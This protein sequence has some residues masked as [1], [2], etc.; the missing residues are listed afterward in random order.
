MEDENVLLWYQD[1]MRV[2][3]DS[4]RVP[5]PMPVPRCHSV[6]DS[7]CAGSWPWDPVHRILG[8]TTVPCSKFIADVFRRSCAWFW[9]KRRLSALRPRSHA[10]GL[11]FSV[12]QNKKRK[13]RTMTGWLTQAAPRSAARPIIWISGGACPLTSGA[14][15]VT[16]SWYSFRLS[17]IAER[18]GP[19]T[20]WSNP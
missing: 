1:T 16:P 17:L 10:R 2:T 7:L 13:K 4:A 6:G 15:L 11:R 20:R 19:R 8:Q 12:H 9:Q 18:R 3:W 14:V 5:M